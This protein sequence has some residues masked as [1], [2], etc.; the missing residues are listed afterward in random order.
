MVLHEGAARLLMIVLVIS[1]LMLSGC[2]TVVTQCVFSHLSWT[3]SR[4][5]LKRNTIGLVKN[6]KSF[7]SGHLYSN[8]FSF[9]YSYEYKCIS[10]LII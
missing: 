6:Q 2:V 9:S 3:S 5:G 8:L 4:E 1:R 10:P 7:M